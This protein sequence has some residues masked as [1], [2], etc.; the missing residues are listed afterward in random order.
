[1]R[2]R[3]SSTL[4]VSG[5]NGVIR[6]V[7]MP[8]SLV[9]TVFLCRCCNHL[10]I[11]L[12]AV[13][14]FLIPG[15]LVLYNLADAGLWT[16]RIP[17][18]AVTLHRSLTPKYERWARERVGS[19]AAMK[20]DN[21]NCAATEW[22]LFGSVFFLW[23]TEALQEA[24]EKDHTLTPQAPKD[25][26]RGAIEA[27]A[28]L[29][30]DPGH[31]E[32]VR[33]KYG[34]NYL[35][36][37]NCFYRMLLIGGLTSHYK[38]SGNG[39]YL[40]LLRDQVETLSQELDAS[41]H[42]L[43]EDYPGECYP[44][45]VHTA[46]ACIC[47][48]D[49]VLGTDHRA[50]AL[51]ARR[52]F[53]GPLQ[54]AHGLPPYMADVLSGAAYDQARGCSNSYLVWFAPELWP[55]L[56]SK[57]YDT[58]EKYYWQ[59]AWTADGFREFSNDQPGG[60]WYMDV[61]SGPVLAG[62]G[63]AACAFGVGAAR[64]NGRFDHAWPLSAEMLATSWPLADGT[65]L[66][67]RILSRAVD[68]LYLGETGLLFTLTRLPAADIKSVQGGSLPLFVYLVLLGY[69]VIGALLVW[70]ALRGLRRNLPANCQPKLAALQVA[71]WIILVMS[72]IILA[73]SGRIVLGLLMV[74]CAHFFPRGQAAKL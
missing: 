7:V 8:K 15:L 45:D 20:L 2:K 18:A 34:S 62:H 58:Y 22:P 72:G 37:D 51:R 39:V 46:I 26:A 50:F 59:H 30:A 1:M 42:G 64:A 60:N 25:Y 66:G 69:F 29:I 31:A 19:G 70:S 38:L 67:P 23:A 36:K 40:P 13:Y 6:M 53:E 61:D 21:D 74:L 47:R 52:A 35:H 43:L 49:K 68:A 56:A 48:A 3:P 71:L 27:A 55:E 73:L 10:L 41:P 32:W 14:F 24:W 17:S 54:D 16:P 12:A 63:I 4:A 65:W 57:W 28:A 9:R 5:K 11:L 44:G 33:Q